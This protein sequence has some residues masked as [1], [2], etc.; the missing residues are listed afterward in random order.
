MT[1]PVIVLGTGGHARVLLA[2][3]QLLGVNVIGLTDSN[4]AVVGEVR[5]FPV[6]GPDEAIL[7]YQPD[8]IR[9]VNGLGSVSKP[10]ARTRLFDRLKR[11]GYFFASVI[12]PS[13]IIAA[14]VS[15][16]EGI[17]IM[18]GAIIQP[19]CRIGDN[20]ILNTGAAV[21]HDCRI[22][23]HV[24]LAPRVTL[25]GDVIIGD[26]VHIGTGAVVI[27]GVGIGEHC[28]IG[29]GTV[30]IDKVPANT[31]MVGVPAREVKG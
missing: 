27:Q 26:G 23:S 30:V 16:G 6:I 31:K 7:R 11:E 22:G 24:H 12:H 10:L 17:Q 2:T 5:G 21:D 8:R 3:L 28:L 19:G 18:A 25:S 20:C 14:D 9:L 29:A 1:Q 13:A 4:P 15:W